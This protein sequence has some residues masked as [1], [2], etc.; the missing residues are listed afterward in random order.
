[1]AKKSRKFS[2]EHLANL[3]AAHAARRGK[4]RKKRGRP[5]KVAAPVGFASRLEAATS[6]YEDAITAAIAKLEI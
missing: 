3:R 4:P 1:M 2:K 6:R 5:A